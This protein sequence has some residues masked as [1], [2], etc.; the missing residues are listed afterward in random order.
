MGIDTR[1][2]LKYPFIVLADMLSEHSGEVFGTIARSIWVINPNIKKAT[3]VV[4][5]TLHAL[6]SRCASFDTFAEGW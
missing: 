4:F 1:F 3:S 5:Q 2:H 6:M